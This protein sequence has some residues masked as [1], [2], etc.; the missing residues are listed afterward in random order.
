MK[1]KEMIVAKITMVIMS[2][3][4]LSNLYANFVK[5]LSLN[6]LNSNKNT[7]FLDF[8]SSFKRASYLF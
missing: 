6:F 8:A 7:R 3:Y 5:N 1:V 4:P 2:G